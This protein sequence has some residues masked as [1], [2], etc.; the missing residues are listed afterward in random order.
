MTVLSTMRMVTTTR[1]PWS[2]DGRISLSQG[3]RWDWKERRMLNFDGFES[4]LLCFGL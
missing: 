4:Q 3:S 1:G 2:N